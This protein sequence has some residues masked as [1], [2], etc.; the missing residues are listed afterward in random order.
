MIATHNTISAEQV[1]ELPHGVETFYHN[2]HRC[3]IVDR[4][5]IRFVK[6]GSNR[7]TG[8]SCI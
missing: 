3:Y 7:V 6:E 1:D 8:I 5:D 2:N 4:T